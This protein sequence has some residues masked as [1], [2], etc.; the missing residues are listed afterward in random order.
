[1]CNIPA[2]GGGRGYTGRSFELT[3]ILCGMYDTQ[4]ANDVLIHTGMFMLKRLE[5][6]DQT[7][8][9]VK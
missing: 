1:M 3:G 4:M 8:M 6:K 5:T 7:D 2:E 9:I